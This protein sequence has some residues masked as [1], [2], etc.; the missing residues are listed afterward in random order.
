MDA[1]GLCKVPGTYLP[2]SQK[3]HL[4]GK[5]CTFLRI[6]FN[7]VQDLQAVKRDVAA[8][9]AR[10]E[11][12]LDAATAYESLQ[13]DIRQVRGL[14][15]TNLLPQHRFRCYVATRK[16]NAPSPCRPKEAKAADLLEMVTGIREYDVPYHVRFATDT[17][18][19]AA[20]NG[21]TCTCPVT[22]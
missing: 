10:N 1:A 20:G 8:A 17:G 12:K 9:V 15:F 21:S 3:N 19:Q 6:G 16:A 18:T 13:H 4:S 5:R 11:A 7:T 14:K 2:H 22:M